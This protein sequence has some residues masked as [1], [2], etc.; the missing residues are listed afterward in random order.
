MRDRSA[1]RALV[2]GVLCLPFGIL[3]PFAIWA[4]AR[5]L[6]RIRRSNDASGVVVVLLAALTYPGAVIVSMVVRLTPVPSRCKPRDGRA[7]P[8]RS[9]S[10][11]AP[12]MEM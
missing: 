11:P 10:S 1:T 5:S 6:Q 7:T 8:P 4:G 9:Y 2:L 12:L 3:S